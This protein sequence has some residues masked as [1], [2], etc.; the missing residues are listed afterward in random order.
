MERGQVNGG[1]T[2]KMSPIS[3]A[4][5]RLPSHIRMSIFPF[6]L[7]FLIFTSYLETLRVKIESRDDGDHGVAWCDSKG[8]HAHCQFIDSVCYDP[9]SKEWLTS[10]LP[11]GEWTNVS[12]NVLKMSRKPF[13]TCDSPFQPRHTNLAHQ[14]IDACSPQGDADSGCEIIYEKTIYV[15]MWIMHFGH[16]LMDMA[17]P[18]YELLKSFGFHDNITIL[19][20][21]EPD[22]VGGSPQANIEILSLL[23]KVIRV[24]DL[25]KATCFHDFYVGMKRHGIY[26]SQDLEGEGYRAF[27]DFV[28]YRNEMRHP[29][30]VCRITILS[31]ASNRRLVNEK[32]LRSRLQSEFGTVCIIKTI[33]MEDMSLEAQIKEVS[34]TSILISVAGSGSHHAIWLPDQGASILILHPA[35]INVN[36]GICSHSRLNCYHSNASF[37]DEDRLS[38]LDEEAIKKLDVTCNIDDVTKQV[39][40]ARLSFVTSN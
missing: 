3:M 17:Y 38:N 27:R 26:G 21:Y 6:F 39:R 15:C 33:I 18:A 23:G 32:E 11:F 24:Q 10:T 30:S 28:F 34:Q 4:K 20:D 12:R 1:R 13:D 16:A 37:L 5:T 31:R 35:N 14:G 9:V 25:Q 7:C 22:D 8:F 19:I 40:E 2:I 29:A 36:L